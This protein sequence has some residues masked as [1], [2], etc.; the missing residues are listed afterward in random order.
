MKETIISLSIYQAQG[1][2]P[3]RCCAKSI[4]AHRCMI[5]SVYVGN[6]KGTS[7]PAEQGIFIS[8]GPDWTQV[9]TRLLC[10]NGSRWRLRILFRAALSADRLTIV[11]GLLHCTGVRPARISQFQYH[12]FT[13]KCATLGFKSIMVKP[14]CQTASQ[15]CSK[16]ETRAAEED[17][18]QQDCR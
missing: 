1:E 13:L 10:R 16:H 17:E 18:T 14:P 2:E 15:S 9:H 7:G 11:L 8:Y 3:S 4:D 6:V 12:M 5:R